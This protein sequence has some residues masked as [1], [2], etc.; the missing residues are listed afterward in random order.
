[1]CVELSLASTLQVSSIKKS[2]VQAFQKW[3]EIQ[4]AGSCQI[5][6]LY[7]LCDYAHFPTGVGDVWIPFKRSQKSQFGDT[8]RYDT[9]EWLAFRNFQIGVKAYSARYM[10]GIAIAPLRVREACRVVTI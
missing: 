8:G 5:K 3:F 1:M 9:Q 6:T 4:C 2:G 10:K 7:R